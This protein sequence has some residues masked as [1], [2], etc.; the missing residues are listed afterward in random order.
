[1]RRAFALLACAAALA[2]PTAG[3]TGS[4]SSKPLAQRLAQ[5]LAV[6]HV[7][8]AHS[9]V[10]AL[11]LTTGVVVFGRNTALSL[12]PASNE[13]LPVTYTA[14][15]ALGPD[16]QIATDVLGQG[17]LVGTT[18]KGSLV[19]QGHGDPTLNDAGLNRLAKQVRAAGVRKVAG[20]VLGDESYFD[21]RRTAPGWKPSFY[22]TQSEPLSALTVDRTWFHTHHSSAPAAA[23][24]SLFKDAL[25]KQGVAV[26]GRAVRGVASP[27]AEELAEVLSPRLSQIVRFMDRESDNFTAELLLKQIGAANGTPGTT[28]AGAA[29]VRTALAEAGVPLAGVRIVD[30]SGLSSLDRLTARAIVGILQAAWG[31]PTIKPSFL[32]AL[33]VAGRSGTLKDRLRKPPALGVVLA[34]TG[35]TSIASALSGYVRDRYVFSVLQNGRP[36]SSFWARR[37]QDRF[38]TV[39]A[40]Q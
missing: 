25:R 33:A 11:D 7:P 31:D 30:G 17:E 24:A 40:A 34:K 19:L 35:T 3:A 1:M 16:Y 13:K 6:P 18:W 27:D 32:S 8:A 21:S 14:L 22:I 15:E 39:L 10:A 23:A 28:A 38:A 12:A 9:G 26:T 20:L 36:V 29:Q 37:A 4:A 2:F 5:A